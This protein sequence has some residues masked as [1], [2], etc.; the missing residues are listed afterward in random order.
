[1]VSRSGVGGFGGGM[2]TRGWQTWSAIG[3]TSGGSHRRLFEPIEV[4]GPP[5][6]C[7]GGSEGLTPN[8]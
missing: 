1:M 6:V 4:V 3:A 2:R 8:A 5:Y 7:A